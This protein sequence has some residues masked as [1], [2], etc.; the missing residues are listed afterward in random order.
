MSR[1][2]DIISSEVCSPHFTSRFGSGLKALLGELS[3]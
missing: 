2:P 1:N 3:K